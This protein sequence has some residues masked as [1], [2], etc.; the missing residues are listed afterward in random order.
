MS[1]Q[2]DH[3]HVDGYLVPS[4]RYG[5]RIPRKWYFRANFAVCPQIFDLDCSYLV[6]N[7]T[8]ITYVFQT[9]VIL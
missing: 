2:S 9:P 3:Y 7:A 6:C 8:K 1:H 5:F 4:P